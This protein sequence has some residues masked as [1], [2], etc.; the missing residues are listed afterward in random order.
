[1]IDNLNKLFVKD[2]QIS[3]LQYV[4]IY[5]FPIISVLGIIYSSW[6]W[7]F[8]TLVG[9]IL[10]KDI[11][12]EIGVH[13]YWTH[14]SFKAKPWVPKLFSI[15]TIL[16]YAGSPLTW[17]YV[18]RHHHEHSDTE[19]DVHSPHHSKWY[20]IWR[21]YW[22]F[23]KIEK[24]D[25]RFVA[26]LLKDESIKFA[27]RY[28]LLIQICVIIITVSIDWRIFVFL[29]ALPSAITFWFGSIAVNM[30]SH[31]WGYRNFET[32]DNSKNNILA[33]ILV[34]S[35]GLQNN[36]HYNPSSNNFKMSDRWYEQ[37]MKNVFLIERFFKA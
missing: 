37:D 21:G 8:L 23:S 25:P 4:W 11:G 33:C 29:F 7:L 3:I 9:I 27:H 12:G 22:D 14:N 5:T 1:M 36:H 31:L 28:H 34:S 19:K 24:F 16:C 15:C 2:F 35:G 30:M 18:H 26:D 13:R 32:P 10:F 20:H 6:H 17:S